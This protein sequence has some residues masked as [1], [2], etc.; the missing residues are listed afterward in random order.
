MQTVQ[1]FFFFFPLALLLTG[2]MLFVIEPAAKQTGY[3]L[4]TPDLIRPHLRFLSSDELEGRETGYRGQRVAARYI[5]SHFERLGLKPM[6][7]SGTYFQKFFV[8]EQKL[9]VKNSITVTTNKGVKVWDK[10]F[11]DFYFLTRNSAGDSSVSAEVVF[12]GYG[13]DAAKDFSYSDYTGVSVK[14]KIALVLGGEPQEADAKSRFNGDSETRWTSSSLKR[15]AAADAGAVALLIVNDL[16]DRQPLK[17]QIAPFRDDVTAGTMSLVD[18]SED[19]KTPERRKSSG[20]QIPVVHISSAV[21]NSLLGGKRIEELRTAIDKSGK[22]NSFAVKGTSVLIQFDKVNRTVESSNVCGLLEGTD[23]ALKEEVIV[24]SAHYDH[25]G[26]SESGLVYNGADDDG[27]GTTAVL[28]LAEAFA[29]NGSRPKR[30]I[31]FM[32]VSGEEKGLLGSKYYVAHPKI[33]L[34][35][36]VVDINIDMI[37]R[38]DPKYEAAKNPNYVYVIGSDKISKDLDD[39]LQRQNKETT[40]LTLDYTYNDDND[41]NRFYYR[42]DHYNFAKNGIPVVF[43]FN[44]THA[45]YHKPG[46]DFEKINFDKMA[47]IVKLAFGVGWEVSNR[48]DGLKKNP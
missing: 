44:G 2:A 21:A 17:D 31:L 48:Q 27:S 38:V 41:P 22:P 6:G 46:D 14:G 10:F 19:G 37:G 29:K 15:I 47:S 32:T 9:G 39:I 16:G 20:K 18:K 5:A 34:A 1:R 13:I 11:D 40:N 26:T 42:S 36:T 12:A 25:V 33:P 8:S 45:D 35:K 3:A 23:A 4:L 24:Y 30:S 28:A 43:F 7:D